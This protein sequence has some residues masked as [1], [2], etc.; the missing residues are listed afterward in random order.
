MAENPGNQAL[1][2]EIRDDLRE[3][4]QETAGLSKSVDALSTSVGRSRRWAWVM[5]AVIVVISLLGVGLCVVVWRN[6]TN[7]NCVRNWANAT[8]NRSAYLSGPSNARIKAEDRLILDAIA[9]KPAAV[10]AT[11]SAI[12]KAAAETFRQAVAAAPVPL[13]Y[14]CR[15]L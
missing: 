9:R 4:K 7:L 1:L 10:L 13:S 3:I 15:S 8:S 2:T 14:N 12:Y 11:D 5:A 6:Y